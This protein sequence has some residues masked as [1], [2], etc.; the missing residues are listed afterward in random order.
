M[1]TVSVLFSRTM[2]PA[3]DAGTG[4]SSSARMAKEG[5][6]EILRISFRRDMEAGT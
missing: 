5:G 6:M 2:N 1:A 3:A 4:A